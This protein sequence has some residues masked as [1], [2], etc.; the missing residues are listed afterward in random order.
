MGGIVRSEG[1]MAP[2]PYRLPLFRGI[3]SV[4]FSDL[5]PTVRSYS[6]ILQCLVLSRHPQSEALCLPE[7]FCLQFNATWLEIRL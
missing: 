2:I 6:K 5:V 7:A 4:S 1:I 3:F